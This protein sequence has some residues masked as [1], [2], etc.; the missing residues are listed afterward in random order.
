MTHTQINIIEELDQ[1]LRDHQLIVDAT[2]A[3]EF[4]REPHIST[5]TYI[6]APGVPL[7]LDKAAQA[8]IFNQLLLNLSQR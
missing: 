6:S 8:K 3:A 5:Q 4:I 7:G 1:T 2:P